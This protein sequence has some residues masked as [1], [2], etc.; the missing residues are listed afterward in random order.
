MK[1]LFVCCDGTWNS[2]NDEFQGVPV[3]TNVVR[4][5]NA[6]EIGATAHGRQLG[7][8]QAGIGSTGNRLTRL[9]NGMFGFGLD[10]DIRSAYKWLA[11]H[12]ENGD[13]IFIVGF[14]R[15]AFTARS[16]TGMLTRCGLP[17]QVTWPLVKQAW[18]LYR[19]PP[20]QPNC[21]ER[22]DAFRKQHGAAPNIRFLGVWDTVGALGIPAQL[23]LCGI[24]RNR[25]RFHNLSLSPNIERA[26]QAIAIDEQRTNFFPTLWEFGNQPAPPYVSQVWFPGVHADVGGGYRETELSDITLQ[27]MIEEAQQCGAVFKAGMLAQVAAATQDFRA[28]AQGILH[29]SLITPYRQ[30]GYCP[31]PIPRMVPDP[32]AQTH[33]ISALALARQQ[34]P[35]IAQ[36]PYRLNID[37][38]VEN[39]VEVRIFAQ[40]PWNWTGIYIEEGAIYQFDALPQQTW[41]DL[42]FCCDANG[43][44]GGK[45]S[46]ALSWAK[47]L[48]EANWFE[49]CGAITLDSLAAISGT[50]PAPYLF[51]IG[52]HC[53]LVAPVSGYLYGFTNDMKGGYWN[54]HGSIQ[55]RI[56]AIRNGSPE[57]APASPAEAITA[58]PTAP[59]GAGSGKL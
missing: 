49:L 13:K 38:F 22:Q 16:L 59:G 20:T 40:A 15:G 58:P 29:N 8:Y 1:R 11:D 57:T 19:L 28:C 55:L 24:F 47:R 2:D 21:Q 33:Q 5:F 17:T 14:S 45:I 48:K 12:Y 10:Q 36:A 50:P 25:Y 53:R 32:S 43:L 51:R 44:P 7:Y 9:I 18:H 30:L 4:F 6:L 23:D 46:A 27:W 37:P 42:H 3:P 56:T 41:F 54:N 34:N 35:P 26:V 39:G 52:T 31:R